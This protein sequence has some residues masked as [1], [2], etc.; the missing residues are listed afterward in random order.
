MK[1][2]RRPRGRPKLTLRELKRRR[3]RAV[4]LLRDGKRLSEVA[5][6]LDVSVSSVY[7][8]KQALAEEGLKA[9]DGKRHPG[10]KCRLLENQWQE[11]KD[12]HKDRGLAD[13]YPDCRDSREFSECVRAMIQQRYGVV[14]A[15]GYIRSL[16]HRIWSEEVLDRAG[17]V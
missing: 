11:L 10:P 7:R 12:M 14:Y 2:K 6:S 5:A 17:L 9:L 16:L 1:P 13:R 4:R 3:V 8:W 15:T